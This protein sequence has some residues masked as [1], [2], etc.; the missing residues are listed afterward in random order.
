M[1][2]EFVSIVTIVSRA[3][4]INRSFQLRRAAARYPQ[5]GIRYETADTGRPTSSQTQ[6][7]LRFRKSRSLVAFS[8]YGDLRPARRLLQPS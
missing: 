3:I 8:M 6:P 1:S 5:S 7:G 4:F 2:S